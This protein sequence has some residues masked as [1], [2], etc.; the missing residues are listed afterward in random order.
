MHVLLLFG[1]CSQ[2]KEIENTNNNSNNSCGITV[3]FKRGEGRK[4]E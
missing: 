1:G 3:D 2:R 4:L